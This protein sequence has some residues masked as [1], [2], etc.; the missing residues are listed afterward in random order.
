MC[1]GLPFLLFSYFMLLFV[2]PSVTA[3]VWEDGAAIGRCR[4]YGWWNE[5]G[6][7][8]DLHPF[9]PNHSTI[10]K[11]SYQPFL[12]L[13][14]VSMATSPPSLPS[15]HIYYPITG[16]YLL[17][18][19]FFNM[20]PLHPLMFYLACILVSGLAEFGSLTPTC[21]SGVSIYTYRTHTQPPFRSSPLSPPRSSLTKN[22]LNPFNLTQVNLT[23]F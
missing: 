2:L 19:I 8:S 21:N 20:S 9:Q 16:I 7:V 23:C 3:S 17:P 4:K 1:H 15:M 18:V 6:C 11:R 22:A 10:F 14:S 5:D 13:S 12:F